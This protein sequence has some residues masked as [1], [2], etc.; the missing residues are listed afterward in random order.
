MTGADFGALA[1]LLGTTDRDELTLSFEALDTLVGGLPPGAWRWPHWWGNN[2]PGDPQA[3]AWL[4]AGFRVSAVELQGFVT[5][6]RLHGRLD[7]LE[8]VRTVAGG[9][10]RLTG[11]LRLVDGVVVADRGARRLTGDRFYAALPDG[12]W[13]CRVRPADG[14]AFLVACWFS[15]REPGVRGRLMDVR[16]RELTA[17]EGRGLVDSLSGTGTVPSVS[18]KLPGTDPSWSGTSLRAPDRNYDPDAAPFADAYQ[19]IR[20]AAADRRAAGLPEPPPPPR[21]TPP[22]EGTWRKGSEVLR[23]DG[24]GILEWAVRGAR[25]FHDWLGTGTVLSVVPQHHKTEVLVRF[26]DGREGWW[27]V[28]SL[29]VRVDPEGAGPRGAPWDR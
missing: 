20:A 11:T 4:D 3:K 9:A 19:A 23:P 14:P 22:T 6:A 17:E 2:Q 5:F 8:V 24:E 28:A 1:S 10:E 7:R 21:P 27:L 25:V 18:T 16:G 26:D 29:L 12:S 13:P 15:L